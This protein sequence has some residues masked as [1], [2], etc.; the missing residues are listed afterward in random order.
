MNKVAKEGFAKVTTART[1][2]GSPALACSGDSSRICWMEVSGTGTAGLGTDSAAA[3]QSMHRNGNKATPAFPAAQGRAMEL[4]QS[5]RVLRFMLCLV[6]GITGFG[7]GVAG[8]VTAVEG[9]A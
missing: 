2:T 6:W 8:R 9:R 1:F 4:Q 3:A 7:Y 5:T